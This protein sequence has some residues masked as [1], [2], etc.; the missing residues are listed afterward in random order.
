MKEYA[1]KSKE[2]LNYALKRDNGAKLVQKERKDQVL[3]YQE[4][5]KEITKIATLKSSACLNI[6]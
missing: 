3:D 4:L 1:E 6:Q 5:M 2:K